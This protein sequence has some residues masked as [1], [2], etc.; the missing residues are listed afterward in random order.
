M[1]LRLVGALRDSLFQSE[2]IMSEKH[3]LRAFPRIEGFRFFLMETPPGAAEEVT[4]ALEDR[5][6]DYGFDVVPTAVR[7]AAFH[8]WKTPISP[9]SRPW[10]AW[11]SCWAPSAWAWCC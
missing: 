4:A 1:R 6:S 8:G 10:A 2:L 5:L 11:D 9:P 3:F 7:L